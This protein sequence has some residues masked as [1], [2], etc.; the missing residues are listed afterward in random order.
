MR[1]SFELVNILQLRNKAVLHAFT[2]CL[3]VYPISLRFAI[4]K[5]LLNYIVG[6]CEHPRF[7]STNSQAFRPILSFLTTKILHAVDLYPTTNT[8]AIDRFVNGELR[9]CNNI[10]TSS[11]GN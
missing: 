11:A 6:V 8:A 1:A 3:G 5:S 10:M 9:H 2:K 4:E 7:N